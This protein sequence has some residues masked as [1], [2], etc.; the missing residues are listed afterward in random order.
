MRRVSDVSVTASLSVFSIR[1]N[2]VSIG[3]VQLDWTPPSEREDSSPLDGLSGYRIYYGTQSG[4][5]ENREDLSNGGL[6]S[7]VLENLAIGTWYIAISA[8]DNNGVE[9]DLSNEVVKPAT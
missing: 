1:V 7:Y 2:A 4:V 3:S 6:T 8:I 9:S 5:Y